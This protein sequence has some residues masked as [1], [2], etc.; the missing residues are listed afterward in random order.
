MMVRYVVGIDPSLASTG[1]VLLDRS[2][3]DRGKTRGFAVTV[4][5]R[6]TVR[7]RVQDPLVERLFQIHDGVGAFLRTVAATS[8]VDGLYI[9]D[10]TDQQF[11]GRRRKLQTVAVLGAAFAASLLAC[12]EAVGDLAVAIPAGEWLPKSKS[13]VSSRGKAWAIPQ[14]STLTRAALRRSVQ[15]LE[16]ANEHEVMAAGVALYGAVRG[17]NPRGA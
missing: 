2:L 8:P 1:L 13:G 12:R 16:K 11:I 10:P 9:E 14:R 15:G 5:R 3:T 6:G 7:T 4:V 17:L